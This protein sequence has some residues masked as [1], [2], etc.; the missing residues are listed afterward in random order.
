MTQSA[1]IRASRRSFTVSVSADQNFARL[2]VG[3]P[4]GRY[5]ETGFGDFCVRRIS[6]GSHFPDEDFETAFMSRWPKNTDAIQ[7]S[8][9]G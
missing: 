3:R 4:T 8:D 1:P 5:P 7:L 6:V 9:F 2:V